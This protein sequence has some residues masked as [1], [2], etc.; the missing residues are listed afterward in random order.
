MP[1]PSDRPSSRRARRVAIVAGGAMA[2]TAAVA[3]P[4]L[5][6]TGSTD[7]AAPPLP[8]L[9][10]D[11]VRTLSATEAVGA[12]F[13]GASAAVLPGQVAG[14]CTGLAAPGASPWVW[15]S[16]GSGAPATVTGLAHTGIRADGAGT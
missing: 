7:E 2:V 1:T 6:A 9:S 10:S 15:T 14:S 5:A 12:W 3:L 11:P 8:A 13:A 16:A 4:A